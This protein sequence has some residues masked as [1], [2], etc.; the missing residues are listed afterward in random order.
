MIFFKTMGHRAIFETVSYVENV[1]QV[2]KWNL[3]EVSS[4][5]NLSQSLVT[6]PKIDTLGPCVAV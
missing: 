2:R 6:R 1:N 3:T 5:S 4:A